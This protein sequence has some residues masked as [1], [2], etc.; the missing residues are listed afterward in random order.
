MTAAED[1][2]LHYWQHVIA[3]RTHPGAH[4]SDGRPLLMHTDVLAFRKPTPAQNAR[5]NQSR[6]AVS[7]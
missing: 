4:E 1:A 6:A 3:L 5:A 2:R 7:A